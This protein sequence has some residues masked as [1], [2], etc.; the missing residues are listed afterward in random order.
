MKK[1]NK[2][3]LAMLLAIVTIVSLFPLT[4][5]ADQTGDDGLPTITVNYVYE[6]NNAMVAVPWSASISKDAPFNQTVA[7]PELPNYY[8]PKT[9][10]KIVGD[11]NFSGGTITYTYDE[12]KDITSAINFALGAVSGDI[13]VTVYYV[14][15]Q[16]DFTVIHHQQ[17]I[18]DDGY[19]VLETVSGK[20]DLDAFIEVAKKEMEGFYCTGVSDTKPNPDGTTVVNVYYNRHYYMVT[21]D[22]NGGI[23]GPAPVYAKYG[24]PI[25]A[26]DL[27]APTRAGYTFAGWFDDEGNE[28]QVGDFVTKNVTY[29]A[30][31]EA[32]KEAPYTYVIWGQN[33]N[34]D[35]Y[36]YLTSKSVMGEVDDEIIFAEVICGHTAHTHSAS[37][38]TSCGF[39][40]EH[41]HTDACYPCVEHSHS[42]D[43]IPSSLNV[44]GTVV[45]IK[46][47]GKDFSYIDDYL[48]DNGFPENMNAG[49]YG[50]FTVYDSGEIWAANDRFGGSNKF[51]YFIENEIV[52]FSLDKTIYYR[53]EYD[54]M[55]SA[56]TSE[57]KGKFEVKCT[58]PEVSGS[59]GTIDHVSGHTASNIELYYNG[60][61][62]ILE[63]PYGIEILYTNANEDTDFSG[64]NFVDD[65]IQECYKNVPVGVYGNYGYQCVQKFDNGLLWYHHP[66]GKQEEFFAVYM[67]DSWHFLCIDSATLV[68]NYEEI[69]AKLDL[70]CPLDEHVHNNCSYDCE[71]AEEVSHEHTENCY[72]SC[73]ESHTHTSEC[74]RYCPVEH[75]HD[76]LTCY[77]R[78]YLYDTKQW[79]LNH[80]ETGSVAADGSTIINV[81]LDRQLF[82]MVFTY[83][84]KYLVPQTKTITKRW[85]ANIRNEWLSVTE[86]AGV[87]VWDGTN[88]DTGEE[89]VG[90]TVYW[91]IMPEYNMLYDEYSVSDNGAKAS[92]YIQN[93]TGDGYTFLFNINAPGGASISKED[94]FTMEGFS[95]DHGMDGNGKEMLT[96]GSYGSFDGA[97]FYYNRK[98]FNL[99]YHAGGSDGGQIVHTIAVPFGAN[100]GAYHNDFKLSAVPEGIIGV[101]KES[102]FAGWYMNPECT[103]PFDFDATTMPANNIPVYAKWDNPAFTVATYTDES[104]ATPFTYEGYDG[105]QTVLKY[106]YAAE[107]TQNPVDAQNRTFVGWFY[108]DKDGTEQAFTFDMAITRDY[109][110]YPKFSDKFPT[111]YTVEYKYLAENG[112]YLQAAPSEEH[113]AMLNETVTV[114]AK[115][116]DELTDLK[117]AGLD[118]LAYFPDKAVQTLTLTAEADRTITFIYTKP[119][120]VSYTIR[121]VDKDNNPISAEETGTTTHNVMTVTYKNIDGYLPRQYQITQSMSA[122][123]QNVFTFVYDRVVTI[124]YAVVGPESNTVTPG[125]ETVLNDDAPKGSTATAAKGYAFVGWYS[126]IECTNLVS[127]DASFVPEKIG[128]NY[129]STYYAKFVE[130]QDVNYYY[131]PVGE[132]TVTVA[133]EKVQELSGPA[134]SSTAVPKTNYKFVDWFTDVDCQN[135]VEESWVDGTT[136]NP[137]MVNG[138]YPGGTFYAKFELD[139]V[140]VTF[141]VVDN[142]GGTVTNPGS[143]PVTIGGSISSTAT[144]ESDYIFVGWF[145]NEDGSGN[146]VSTNETLN[147]TD[148]QAEA[149][150]YAKFEKA[151]T[152][153]YVV[154]IGKG[155]VTPGSETVAAVSGIATGSAPAAGS[156]YYFIGWFLDKECTNAVPNEW[157]VDGKLTP[158]R[159]EGVYQ[160]AYYA[161]F[162]PNTLT[163]TKTNGVANEAYIMEVFDDSN[164]VVSRVVV[165]NG[166]SVTI[167][168]L[169]EGTY[170]VRE[171][172][173]WSWRYAPTYDKD[174]VTIS[175]TVHDV[176]VTV[177]NANKTNTKWL[178]AADYVSNL[179][180]PTKTN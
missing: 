1:M 81:Y 69:K 25:D 6:R 77:K 86:E 132:G 145:S 68:E 49:V 104:L 20:G 142:I 97:E 62:V 174:S 18:T 115:M 178:S 172:T 56:L 2:R 170:R 24:T 144:A 84:D 163:I 26:A 14:A 137:Q 79:K 5:F 106:A 114:N 116:G 156:G 161:K 51:M 28:L 96:P 21:L 73:N 124:N 64:I 168:G 16:V 37:C 148:V 122:T 71:Y 135:H 179:F 100:A 108:K 131:I 67:Y 119:G 72:Y 48:W 39:N 55:Q 83:E 143:N 133:S 102:T 43:C 151:F 162:A 87:L 173:S 54:I 127:K 175:S 177:S 113:F 90:Q 139:A 33:A 126:D 146:A 30:K 32:V 66:T 167:A 44:D 164:N 13:S 47:S 118:P 93:L 158:Q 123:E 8:T 153:N 35:N 23:N 91:E 180:N 95:Y 138:K 94:F 154:S 70:T 78:G 157:V 74:E 46:P 149:A 165:T 171:K 89:D 128:G 12:S 63:E 4:V 176:T 75:E 117:N 65:Y 3:I 80:A 36:S 147:V 155:E 50:D 58:C 9:K 169:P 125:F 82:D 10:I 7:V 59:P 17:N 38:T 120:A 57:C 159:V 22:A 31:W 27:T 45:V 42:A 109:H 15:K 98:N 112:E 150:Y 52:L 166:K 19:S 110:L 34:D 103:Q 140:N 152:I 160:N 101:E 41:I 11:E 60:G 121:Y 111:S 53:D 88:L 105:A 134:P 107:L 99:L 85:G 130:D 129:A 141:G 76:D 92:Y 40:Y 61:K 136:L 29:R